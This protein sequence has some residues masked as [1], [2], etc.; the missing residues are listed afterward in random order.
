MILSVSR[1]TDIPAFYGEWFIKRLRDGFALVRNPVN[2]K[3]VSKIFLSKENIDCIVFWTKNPKNMM[4]Y[5]GEL[6]DYPF[7]FQFTLNGY[8]KDIEPGI[9]DKKK[10]LIP[11]F[12]ELSGMIGKERVIW[13]YDPVLISRAYCLERHIDDFEAI[14]EALEGYTEQA[15]ISFLDV[16]RK[17]KKQLVRAEIRSLSEDE[18][19]KFAEK[20]GTSAKNHGMSAVTCAEHYDLSQFGIRPGCCI[21]QR[22]VEKL[23]GM[24]IAVDKDKNQRAAC[25]CAESIDIGTYD[26]CPGGCIYCYANHSKETIKQVAARYCPQAS[27]LCGQPDKFDEIRERNPGSCAVSQ[28][29]FFENSGW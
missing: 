20:A 3:Q 11:L 24:N 16:Y 29:S 2:P 23:I 13:R 21:D 27:M 19:F 28:L 26:T 14:A 7:Y 8:G 18:V 5:L 12:R 6:E 15:V 9:P 1:R 22:L 10:E 25:G 17:I 4:N